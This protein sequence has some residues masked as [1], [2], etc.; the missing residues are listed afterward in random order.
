[1]FGPVLVF[2]A[3]VALVATYILTVNRLLRTDEHWSESNQVKAATK[4]TAPAGHG[5]AEFPAH[6]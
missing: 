4:T 3:A 2:A 1:M 6:A 5:L